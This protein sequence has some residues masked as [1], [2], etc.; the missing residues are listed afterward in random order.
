MVLLSFNFHVILLIFFWFLRFFLFIIIEVKAYALFCFEGYA[1]PHLGK[2]PQ[3]C[4]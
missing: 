2:T 3:D 1:S 4:L